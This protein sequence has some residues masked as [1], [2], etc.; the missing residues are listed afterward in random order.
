MQNEVKV[1]GHQK[2]R[3]NQVALFNTTWQ[4]HN[5]LS[6][7]EL[8]QGCITFW[9]VDCS[10]LDDEHSCAGMLDCNWPLLLWF[11]PIPKWAE[12]DKV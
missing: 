1:L 11:C 4:F 10:L 12:H 6:W 9:E 7:M 2:K 8:W 5:F 3:V